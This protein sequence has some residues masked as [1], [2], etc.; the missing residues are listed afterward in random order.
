M[1][2]HPLE[3]LVFTISVIVNPL[4]YMVGCYT[5]LHCILQ[6]SITVWAHMEAQC[7]TVA[8]CVAHIHANSI[9]TV[10]SACYALASSA[11]YSL[12]LM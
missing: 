9:P 10:T 2:T 11:M 8:S 3:P 6:Y 4:K 1:A 5:V 12:T 7:N